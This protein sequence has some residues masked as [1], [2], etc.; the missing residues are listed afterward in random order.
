MAVLPAVEWLD[1]A[2]SGSV[3]DFRKLAR[4]MKAA[5]A[6]LEFQRRAVELAYLQILRPCIGYVGAGR[7][8]P[9]CRTAKQEPTLG[10]IEKL[11]TALKGKVGGSGSG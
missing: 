9:G 10:T 6:E 11:A 7:I 3:C 8:W 2:R 5:I 4:T 1:M